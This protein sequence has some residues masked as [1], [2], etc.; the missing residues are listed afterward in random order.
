VRARRGGGVSVAQCDPSCHS[1]SSFSG[2]STGT[3]FTQS[4]SHDTWGQIRYGPYVSL[5]SF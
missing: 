5:F 2:K 3:W 1:W 4:L